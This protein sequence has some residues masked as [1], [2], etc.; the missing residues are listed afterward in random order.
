MKILV[1][2]NPVPLDESARE[3]EL[4]RIIR[5]LH[6]KGE[7]VREVVLDGVR[8]REDCLERIAENAGTLQ[9]LLIY[10]TDRDLVIAELTEELRV[11]LPKIL[12]ALDSI[13]ELLYGEMTQEDWK[14]VGQLLE[15]MGWVT[16]AVFHMK[17]HADKTGDAVRA[18]GLALFLER[19]APLIADIE[20]FLKEGDLISAGDLLKYEM[21]DL[22]GEL[23]ARLEQGEQA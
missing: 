1:N 8:Y 11:Y 20:R 23:M 12:Q 2:G 14:V 7:I 5:E 10:T 4:N 15:G 18:A 3:T 13:P 9:E 19:L 6:E 16:Q 17:Q 21:P 22:F